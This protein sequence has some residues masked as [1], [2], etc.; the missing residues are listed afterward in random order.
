MKVKKRDS[1]EVFC[2]Y[3][4]MS[5]PLSCEGRVLCK[6]NGVVNEDYKCRKFA[7]DPLK[8][9]P[10]IITKREENLEFPAI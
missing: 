7:Y 6:K 8:R 10:R 5:E 9:S 4:E 3:C 2:K 1:I